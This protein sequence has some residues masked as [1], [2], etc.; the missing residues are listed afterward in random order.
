MA[1]AAEKAIQAVDTLQ[2][3]ASRYGD[4]GRAKAT[5][6]QSDRLSY[7]GNL[8]S[9]ARPLLRQA[10]LLRQARQTVEDCSDWIVEVVNKSVLQSDIYRGIANLDAE[11]AARAIGGHPP[12]FLDKGKADKQRAADNR[13]GDLIIWREI[14]RKSTR[15]NSSH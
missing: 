3:D 9:L 2:V 6:E 15:L 12:G 4:D 13:Y 11:F 14:D 10:G 5:D 1:K 7:L 8:D